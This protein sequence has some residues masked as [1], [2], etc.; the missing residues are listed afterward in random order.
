MT[1]LEVDNLIEEAINLNE[2]KARLKDLTTKKIN[3]LKNKFEEI[4]YDINSKIKNLE[5]QISF[6]INNCNDKKETKTTFKKKFI[7][8]EVVITK[9]HKEIANPNL[10][11]EAARKINE[12][13]DH[14][15]S[16]TNYKFEW[17]ELKKKLKLTESGKI[18]DKETGEDF[19]SVLTVADVPEKISIKPI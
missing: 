17:G 13:K 16:E 8:G 6:E 15:K 7:S 12:F 1:D 11:G 18:V 19:T 14:V 2:E 9:A 10:E 5:D 4:E 3:F